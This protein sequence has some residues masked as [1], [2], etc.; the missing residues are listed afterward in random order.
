MRCSF[1]AQQRASLLPFPNADGYWLL[2]ELTRM[3][4]RPRL[5]GTDVTSA[6]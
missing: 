5:V 3:C 1:V 2:A 4:P 6:A